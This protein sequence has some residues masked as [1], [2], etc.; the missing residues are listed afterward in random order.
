M[1][2]TGSPTSPA[3]PAG[4]PAETGAPG[5]VWGTASS[6]T[7]AQGAAARS[8]WSGWEQAGVV[9]RSAD[10]N[11]FATRYAEDLALLAESG[12]SHH[13]LSLDWA[14]LEPEAGRRDSDAVDHALDVLA[15]ARR[16]GVEIWLCLHHRTSPG[17]FIDDEGGFTDARSRRFW[18]R[19]VDW[20][21]ETF[22]DLVAGWIPIDQP[23][24]TAELLAPGQATATATDP[25]AA[26]DV[27][28]ES[29]LLADHEAWRLLR[30][31]DPPVATG[32]LLA[33]VEPAVRGREPDERQAADARADRRQAAMWCWTEALAEGVLD[34]GQR[35]PVVRDDLAGAYDLIGFTYGYGQSVY[36]DEVGPYPADGRVDQTGSAPWAEGLGLVLRRLAEIL[37][38][39]RQ[40]VTGWGVATDDDAWR[41]DLL[42]DV[43]HQLE[44]A[45]A[46]GIDVAGLLHWTAVDGYEG[47][48]GF[49]LTYGLFDRDRNPRPS[50]ELVGRWAAERTA[51]RRGAVMTDPADEHPRSCRRGQGADRPP[52]RRAGRRRHAGG[53]G[54]RLDG[55]LHHRGPG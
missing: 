9:P 11:G 20:M 23:L 29:L 6:S 32:H 13:R 52:R 37:P 15:E 43:R 12:I 4:P 50:A 47:E 44:T 26:F 10:G 45:V 19:H 3:G 22:G 53:P 7:Q 8:D 51:T 38:G 1:S 28:L 55:A 46:D 27:V 35:A 30:G 31:G 25:T 39:R 41:C 5:L 49:G 33:P 17:W 40:L 36:V 24:V 54:H 34:V 21:A 14:R 42:R 2:Q 48:A 18:H 16:V